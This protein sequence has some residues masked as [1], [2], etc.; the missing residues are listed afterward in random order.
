M[1]KNP[2]INFYVDCLIAEAFLS[3]K[4]IKQAQESESPGIMS[5]MSGVFNFFSD[6][7]GI[8]GP[9][10]TA[11]M[12]SGATPS[13][14]DK[15]VKLIGYLAPAAI[16]MT[17]RAAG[18]GVFV[19]FLTS[20]AASVFRIPIEEIIADIYNKIK[21]IITSGQKV[22]LNQVGNIVDTS[23]DQHTATTASLSIKNL[24][25]EIRNAQLIK[26]AFISYQNNQLSSYAANP[27]TS[28]SRGGAISLIKN[29]LGGFFK[30][31][32]LA[33]GFAVAGPAIRKMFGM[34]EEKETATPVTDIEQKQKQEEIK[35]VMSNINLGAL[36]PSYRDEQYNMSPD[37]YWVED[38]VAGK[39]SIEQM[40][41]DF[42]NDV[43]AGYQ[44]K[45]YAIRSSDR[46]NYLADRILF[47]NSKNKGSS[48]TFI[49]FQFKTKKQVV[50]FFL[51]EVIQTLKLNPAP[52]MPYMSAPYNNYTQIPP[53]LPST[54]S[55]ITVSEFSKP[56]VTYPIVISEKW[57][58]RM[59]NAQSILLSKLTPAEQKKVE[60]Y[61]NSLSFM[62]LISINNMSEAEQVKMF[63]D[64]V[65]ENL[66]EDAYRRVNS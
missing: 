52:S 10:S 41:I 36:N 51:P 14:A 63:K 59:N 43:Y 55:T 32:L 31:A 48:Y 42:T 26:A 30:M 47:N 28:I 37:S 17:M 54:P 21:N 20:A 6:A 58:S 24:D 12:A 40:L 53:S 60:E 5:G 45:E 4:L 18:L 64:M 9:N 49:P 16:Y 66:G 22:P 1:S 62:D 56:S 13:T 3:D 27:L 11:P 2:D 33:A 57:K 23:V 25:K 46:F 44:D 8:S 19:S 29:I 65:K 50:N 61:L 35:E 7:L 39:K 38:Y 15:A 34:P